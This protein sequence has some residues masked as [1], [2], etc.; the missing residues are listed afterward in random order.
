MAD[1]NTIKFIGQGI[2]FPIKLNS[3]GRPDIETGVELIRSSLKIIL[4]WPYA[5]RFFLG[6]FGA[7]LEEL[8]EEPNDTIIKS[9]VRH[10]VIDS[11]SKFETRIE[12]LEVSII[13]PTATSLSIKLRYKILSS[14]SED[15]F[16]FPFYP[17]IKY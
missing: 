8:L 11:I 2:T 3:Q 1:L 13:N 4:K 10:F 17:K 16:I 5:T 7:R 15:T 6:E 9:L 12:L 14:Q